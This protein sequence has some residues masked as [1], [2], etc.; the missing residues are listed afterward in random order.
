MTEPNNN[1][2]GDQSKGLKIQFCILHN[3]YFVY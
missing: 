2:I 3:D 1:L